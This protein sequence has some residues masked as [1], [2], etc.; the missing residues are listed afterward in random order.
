MQRLRG[1]E[2]AHDAAA[3]LLT[4]SRFSRKTRA[5][6]SKPDAHFEEFLAELRAQLKEVRAA[7]VRTQQHAYA[8]FRI[9]FPRRAH[10]RAYPA[11]TPEPRT[12]I[13]IP[14]SSRFSGTARSVAISEKC[15][16]ASDAVAI[17]I[18]CMRCRFQQRLCACITAD[19]RATTMSPSETM[20][21]PGICLTSKALDLV[22]GAVAR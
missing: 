14:R 10:C 16:P 4:I 18:R 22:W 12:S 11:P 19:C 13:Q 5:L 9:Q 21:S 20:A 3:F 17:T 2:P 15:F 6:M 7:Q 8:C 1:E